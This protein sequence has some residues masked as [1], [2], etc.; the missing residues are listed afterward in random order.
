MK[1]DPKR[2][3]I[4][5]LDEAIRR[6]TEVINSPAMDVLPG[7]KQDLIEYREQLIREYNYEQAGKKPIQ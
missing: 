2:K 4:K 5:T 6:I 1:P 7:T 3:P